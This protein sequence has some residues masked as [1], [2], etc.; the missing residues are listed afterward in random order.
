MGERRECCYDK[1]TLINEGRLISVPINGTMDGVLQ[2]TNNIFVVSTARHALDKFYLNPNLLLL[3][4][5]RLHHHITISK[6]RS[7]V[8]SNSSFRIR[9][10]VPFQSLFFPLSR[11]PLPRK[12]ARRLCN[13]INC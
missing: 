12:N 4:R 5:G 6:T 1:S 7:D 9:V 3:S 2:M 13:A 10:I 8:V 11:I